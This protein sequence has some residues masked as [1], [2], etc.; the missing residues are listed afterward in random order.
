MSDYYEKDMEVLLENIETNFTDVTTLTNL[1]A[2]C[3][4]FDVISCDK[5]DLFI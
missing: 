3:D 5:F 1:L 4:K 2:F